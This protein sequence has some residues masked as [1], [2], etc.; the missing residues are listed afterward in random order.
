MRSRT[1]KFGGSAFNTA[2]LTLAITSSK[3]SRSVFRRASCS[4]RPNAD[5][6]SIS[7]R[8][9]FLVCS[10]HSGRFGLTVRIRPPRRSRFF[11]VSSTLTKVWT[12]L[13]IIVCIFS[14]A[15]KYM[16]SY[17][18]KK[19]SLS[20]ARIVSSPLCNVQVIVDFTI[21]YGIQTLS[22]VGAIKRTY[23]S[24]KPTQQRLIHAQSMWRWFKQ[25][26]QL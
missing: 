17:S 24:E 18:V 7:C 25:L 22:N 23:T 1:L 10:L 21:N 3:T 8:I 20:L 11:V 2:F 14:K 6:L 13:R 12:I 26:T 9:S 16:N 19:P 4:L 15:R 5:L